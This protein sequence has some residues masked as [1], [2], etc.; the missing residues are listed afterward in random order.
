MPSRAIF[1]NRKVQF[2]LVWSAAPLIKGQMEIVNV[3]IYVYMMCWGICLCVCVRAE[4]LTTT[5]TMK[6]AAAR[7]PAAKYALCNSMG[8]LS[9]TDEPKVLSLKFLAF[10]SSTINSLELTTVSTTNSSA[11]SEANMQRENECKWLVPAGMTVTRGRTRG[12]RRNRSSGRGI[13][14]RRSSRNSRKPGLVAAASPVPSLVAPAGATHIF[15][16]TRRRS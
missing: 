15:R 16:V 13:R 1:K 6:M 9:T 14:W 3:C 8:L 7:T 11:N 4:E 2:P 10:T 5:A 12:S